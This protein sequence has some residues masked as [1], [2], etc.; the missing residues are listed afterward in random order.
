[1]SESYDALVQMRKAETV[2]EIAK[3][4]FLKSMGWSEFSE[5][6][7]DNAED[8]PYWKRPEDKFPQSERMAI[9][10]AIDGCKM[11]HEGEDEHPKDYEGPCWCRECLSY[12][13]F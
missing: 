2:L 3:S 9:S 12:G 11:P 1:M 13:D 7:Y 10:F 4:N 8:G 5:P 6:P